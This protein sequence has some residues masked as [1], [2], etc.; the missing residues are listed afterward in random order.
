[1][2]VSHWSARRKAI[3]PTINLCSKLESFPQLYL[4]QMEIVHKD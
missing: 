4:E 3:L 1:M 2:I